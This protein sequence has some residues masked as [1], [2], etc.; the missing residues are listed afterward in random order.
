MFVMRPMRRTSA[1]ATSP[2]ASPSPIAHADSVTVRIETAGPREGT[3]AER[4]EVSSDGATARPPLVPAGEAV[5]SGTPPSFPP[6][7]PFEEEH[8]RRLR[9]SG[10]DAGE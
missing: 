3:R 8:R 9:H 2:A 5:G 1:R 7:F 10:D 6:V 4:S